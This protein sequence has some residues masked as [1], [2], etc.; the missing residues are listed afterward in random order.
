[1]TIGAL[2]VS[3]SPQFLVNADAITALA[4]KHHLP[5]IGALEFTA[6]GGIL[7]Y[8]M[9]FSGSFRRAADVVDKILKGAKPG[10]IPIERATKSKFVLNLKTAKALGLDIPPTLLARA[11]IARRNFAPAVSR[12]L[13]ACSKPGCKFDHY[14]NLKKLEEK[15]NEDL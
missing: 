11:Q 2:V 1:M 5:S 6:S 8:G 3:D 7:A 12:T 4:A 10:D 15:L 13:H 9:N 14:K